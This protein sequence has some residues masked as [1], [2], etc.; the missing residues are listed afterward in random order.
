MPTQDRTPYV[1]VLEEESQALATQRSAAYASR[2]AAQRAEEAEL[3]DEAARAALGALS[4]GGDVL[5]VRASAEAALAS[6]EAG[7][8]GRALP[9]VLDEFGRDEN[10][11]ARLQLKQRYAGS[12][13]VMV[14]A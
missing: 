12:V 1:E 9:V 7:L 8:L 3:T 4:Q 5:A 11:A 14:W 2:T 6:A 13:G 10:M